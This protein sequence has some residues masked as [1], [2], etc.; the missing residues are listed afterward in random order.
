V[1]DFAEVRR[2]AAKD[3]IDVREIAIHYEGLTADEIKQLEAHQD[4]SH[5]SL[6][7]VIA[8]FPTEGDPLFPEKATSV[9]HL[10]A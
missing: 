2:N 4:I 5:R 1:V 10:G 7:G 3:G 8:K 6:K 9:H